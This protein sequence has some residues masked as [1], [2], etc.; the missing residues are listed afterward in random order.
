MNGF[1]KC[2]MHF[3]RSI[4]Q[5][6]NHFRPILFIKNVYAIK[7][8]LYARSYSIFHPLPYQGCSKSF[9]KF[10]FLLEQRIK[11]FFISFYGSPV[12]VNLS[13]S[14]VT[15]SSKIETHAAYSHSD[16]YPGICARAYILKQLSFLIHRLNELCPE[17]LSY[18]MTFGIF[19]FLGTNLFPFFGRTLNDSK[20]RSNRRLA[21]DSDT[22]NFYEVEAHIVGRGFV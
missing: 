6:R 10:V 9:F 2:L 20:K 1:F 13:T 22:L 4:Y 8:I 18:C 17:L 5:E 21:F 16:S 11:G 12:N 7:L 3:N 14:I 19:F 15:R